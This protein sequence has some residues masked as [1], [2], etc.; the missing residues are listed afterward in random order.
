M[1]HAEQP[2]KGLDAATWKVGRLLRTLAP[3]ATS[4][5][6]DLTN[7][8]RIYAVDAGDT[9]LDMADDTGPFDTETLGAAD[10][11]LR[12]TLDDAEPADLAAAGWEPVADDE[13]AHLYRITFPAPRP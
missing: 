13:S 9:E 8:A 6:V 12:Q 5:L 3:E 4:A 11:A 7:L 1:T 10:E 2:K